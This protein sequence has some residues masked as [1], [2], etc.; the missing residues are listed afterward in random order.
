MRVAFLGLGRMG[1]PMAARLVD[2]GVDLLVWNRSAPAAARLAAAGARVAGSADQAVAGA[3]VVLLMLA[4]GRVVHEVLR[5]QDPGFAARMS[6]RLVVNLG[7][8]A[9]SAS[10]RLH[11][12]LA[13]V[14][15]RYVEAPVSGSRGPAMAG[16]L[17]IMVGGGGDDVRVAE[18]LLA[19][20]AREIVRCGPVPCALEMK[21]AVNTFLITMVAGLAEAFAYGEQRGVDPALLARILDAGPMASAVSRG[22]L[23]KLLAADVSAQA[24]VRDVREICRLILQSGAEAGASLPLTRASE[25]LLGRAEALGLGTADMIAMVRALRDDAVAA[26]AGP[27]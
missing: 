20:L 15:A 25:A 19:P 6:G 10:R 13:E 5:P 17:V 22:K 16:D 1:E 23:A 8:V 4:D 2:A 27:A 9:P 21:L 26:T 7:T 12:R 18:P 11:H 14:G 24:A 3:D